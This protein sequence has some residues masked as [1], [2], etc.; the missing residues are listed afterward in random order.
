MSASSAIT[1]ISHQF[2]PANRLSQFPPPEDPKI[3]LGESSPGWENPT[4]GIAAASRGRLSAAAGSSI[5]V[6]AAADDAA[7]DWHNH[8]TLTEPIIDS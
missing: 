2:E 7:A 6:N 3:P 1:S 5:E 8:V 4:V